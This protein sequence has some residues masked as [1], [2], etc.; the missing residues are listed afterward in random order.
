MLWSVPP[1]IEFKR[2]SGQAQQRLVGFRDVV[3]NAVVARTSAVDTDE[4][5]RCIGRQ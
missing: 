3:I 4:V 2:I 1:A 5:H